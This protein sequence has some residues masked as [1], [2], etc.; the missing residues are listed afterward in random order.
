MSQSDLAPERWAPLVTDGVFQWWSLDDGN[1]FKFRLMIIELGTSIACN[2]TY[3]L[4]ET[5]RLGCLTQN[6]SEYFELILWK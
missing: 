4:Q 3:S 5:R 2:D 6:F 1:G